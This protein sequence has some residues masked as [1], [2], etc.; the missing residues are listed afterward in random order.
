LEGVLEDLTYA[1]RQQKNAAEIHGEAVCGSLPNGRKIQRGGEGSEG[2]LVS[3]E[4]RES[5]RSRDGEQGEEGEAMSVF[6][7]S[8][9]LCLFVTSCLFMGEYAPA[10]NWWNKTWFGIYIFCMA[11]LAVAVIYFSFSAVK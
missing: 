2:G 4:P 11:V 10:G 6:I 5:H 1:I 7:V 9:W 8:G 3:T